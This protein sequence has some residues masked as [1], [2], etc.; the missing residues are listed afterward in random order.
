[1][2]LTLVGS[3]KIKLLKNE[4][5]LSAELTD[6]PY[7]DGEETS[8]LDTSDSATAM[9]KLTVHKYVTGK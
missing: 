4:E 8:S 2:P 7:S 5:A 1:M 6:R 9:S 3:A